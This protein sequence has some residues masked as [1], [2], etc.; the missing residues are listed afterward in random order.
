MVTVCWVDVGYWCLFKASGLIIDQSG[1]VHDPPP[2][3]SVHVHRSVCLLLFLLEKNLAAEKTYN[4]LDITVT[5]ALQHRSQYFEGVLTCQAHETL[6][7][8]ISRLVEAE[9]NRTNERT[10]LLRIILI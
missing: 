2:L 5:K 8:I 4:N 10:L 1:R 6:E 9:V 3:S 7:A